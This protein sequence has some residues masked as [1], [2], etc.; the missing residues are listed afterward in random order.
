MDINKD[1]KLDFLGKKTNERKKVR[2][3]EFAKL[4]KSKIKYEI[5]KIQIKEINIILR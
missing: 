3:T 5:D 1:K 2:S 4:Q